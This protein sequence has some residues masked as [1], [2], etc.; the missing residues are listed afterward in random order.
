MIPQPA[1]MAAARRA[2]I[3]HVF[4]G[5]PP[6]ASPYP[7]A[8]RRHRVWQFTAQTALAEAERFKSLFSDIPIRVQLVEPAR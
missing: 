3:A 8:T 6:P 2:V 4:Q 7:H 1:I 5:G